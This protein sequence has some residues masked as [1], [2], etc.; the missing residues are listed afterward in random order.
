MNI[1]NPV[2]SV[3]KSKIRL[4]I[5]Y[6]MVATI[7]VLAVTVSIMWLRSKVLRAEMADMDA[8]IASL[9]EANIAQQAAIDTITAVREVDGEILAG[10]VADYETIKRGDTAT[11][12]R[13]SALEKNN[14]EVLRYLDSAVPDE[15]ACV[16]DKT[17]DQDGDG[18]PDP[19]EGAAREV[20]QP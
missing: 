9:N 4:W 8:T 17:C 12:R 2:T 19:T 14:A 1:E 3:L 6:L 20:Q 7:I 15:L 5:E 18:V 10:L 13:I 11:A 16:L